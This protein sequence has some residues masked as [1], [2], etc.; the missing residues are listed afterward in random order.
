MNEQE[1]NEYIDYYLKFPDLKQ[2]LG[3]SLIVLTVIVSIILYY[4]SYPFRKI[5]NF[6]IKKILNK[7]I[8]KCFYN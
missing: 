4:T 6:I 3:I 1:F 7:R 8:L 5:K 2:S